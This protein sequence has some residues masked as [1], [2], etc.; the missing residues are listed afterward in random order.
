MF[1]DDDFDVR[2]YEHS[3]KISNGIRE[4]EESV[5]QRNQMNFN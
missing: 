2:F 4:T 1:D 3:M 5:K